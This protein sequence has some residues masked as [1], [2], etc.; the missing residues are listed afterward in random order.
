VLLEHLFADCG[1]HAAVANL[2]TRNTASRRLVES[3]GFVYERMIPQADT[4]KGTVSH[5]FVFRL[6]AASSR[7]H[8]PTA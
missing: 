7:R 5:E 6:T 2:D 1:A 3:L 8:T 4:F